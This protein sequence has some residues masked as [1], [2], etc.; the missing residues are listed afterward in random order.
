MFLETEYP[1]HATKMTQ[2]LDLS[3]FDA[4]IAVGGDGT[5]LGRS[6]RFR[7]FC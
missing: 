4:I 7:R 2:E 3:V 1:G 6:L 5:L